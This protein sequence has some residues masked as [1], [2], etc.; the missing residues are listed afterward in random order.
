MFLSDTCT[1]TG[2]WKCPP[3]M[4]NNYMCSLNA[5]DTIGQFTIVACSVSLFYTVLLITAYLGLICLQ[6]RGM[7]LLSGKALIM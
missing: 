5:I 7:S 2:T 6:R 1:G 4:I 3:N